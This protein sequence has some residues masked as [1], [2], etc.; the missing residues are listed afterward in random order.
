M[1][2]DDS[3]RSSATSSSSTSSSVT[4]AS[5]ATNSSEDSLIESAASVPDVDLVSL[6]DEAAAEALSLFSSIE[7]DPITGQP[8]LRDDNNG[9]KSIEGNQYGNEGWLTHI[10]SCRR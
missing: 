4:T 3:S 2:I 9:E 6:E 7:I 8:V 5:S 10:D 1:D